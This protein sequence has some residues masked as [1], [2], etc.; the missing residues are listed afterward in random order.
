MCGVLSYFLCL[1][2]HKV[3]VLLLRYLLG[4]KRGCG[5]QISRIGCHRGGEF[6]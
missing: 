5:V 2:Y 1:R 6:N 3:K 4:P